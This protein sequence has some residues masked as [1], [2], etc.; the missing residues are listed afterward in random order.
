MSKYLRNDLRN[1]STVYK[2][3]QFNTKINIL[4]SN[5]RDDFC[6]ATSTQLV[7]LRFLLAQLEEL[8]GD[9]WDGP[10]PVLVQPARVDESQQATH[11]TQQHVALILT[12]TFYCLYIIFFFPSCCII[13]FYV[14]DNFI[15]IHIQFC[16]LLAL[17]GVITFV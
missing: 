3:E 12:Q 6:D 10:L 9:L 8:T 13:W 2:Y 11:L 7:Q 14:P 16:I 15:V 17:I 4:L 1:T 5:L